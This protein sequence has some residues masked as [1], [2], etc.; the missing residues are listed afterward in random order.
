MINTVFQTALDKSS[1]YIGRTGT[2]H[3]AA[4]FRNILETELGKD[5]EDAYFKQILSLIKKR[6]SDIIWD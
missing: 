4:K 6:G 1:K 3:C 2:T 5:W